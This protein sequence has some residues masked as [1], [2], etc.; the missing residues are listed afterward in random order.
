MIIGLDGTP[1]GLTS[2]GLRRYTEELVRGLAQL[3]PSDELH[4][5]AAGKYSPPAYASTRTSRIITKIPAFI[6]RRWWLAGLPI[7]LHGLHA[8][9]FHGTNYEVPYLPL[10]PSV[11]TVHDLSPWMR[12]EW[13]ALADRVKRRA[14]QL[15][16]LG[17]ATMVITYTEAVRRQIIDYFRLHPSRVVAIPAAPPP[18]LQPCVYSTANSPYFLFVGTIEPRKNLQTLLRAWR[19]L[20]R[21][22]DIELVIAGRT[23]SDAQ[24]IEPETGLRLLNE[25]PDDD[26]ARLYSGAIAVVYPSLYEGFGLPVVEAMQCGAAVIASRDGALLEVSGGAAL[27]A[28]ASDVRAWRDAMILLLDNRTEC[29]RR[30]E[31]SLARARQFSWRETARQTR[32]VY[33]E[34]IQR[35]RR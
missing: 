32:E 20:R 8:D 5:L 27:H 30:R 23:R 13:H 7:C 33:V 18:W 14:P 31:L 29:L 12:P 21:S 22:Y 26:L 9:V 16:R 19:E 28:D 3:N 17:I 2:G 6:K 4:V 10:R 15:L 1:L 11:V 25:V 35:F 24:P 34:A